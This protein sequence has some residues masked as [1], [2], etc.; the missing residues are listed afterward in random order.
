MIE[1]RGIPI[2]ADEV[3]IL[4]KI[5]QTVLQEQGR[6]ILHKIKKSGN[7]IQVCCPI[8]NQGQERNPSCG[9]ITIKRKDYPAGTF[10]C[11][12]CGAKGSFEYFVSK[13]FQYEDPAFGR[14]WLLDNFVQGDLYE[15]PELPLDFSR[16][17]ILEKNIP[18]F[19]YI[20]EEELA[21]Y[22][23]YH[24]YMFQRKLTHEVIDKYDVGYQKD[25]RLVTINEDGTRK[26]WPPCECL[27][28][29]VKDKY[30][31]C[32]FVSRRAI[33]SKNFY[34]PANMEKPVYGIYELPH[35]CEDV[36]I[37]ESVINALTC[38][39]YGR[40]AVA[41]FGTGNDHQIKQL[42]SLP[43]RHF[44][45]ALD[46]DKAGNKGTWKLK[47]KLKNKLLTKFII[48][49]GKDINDLTYDEFL[50]LPEIYI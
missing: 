49:Q 4:I 25:F 31:N 27:T 35:G 29:P 26:I 15:R 24:P 23:Y 42:N 11:F 34:L 22:R 5:R 8:H 39:G 10:N 47:Y 13:C 41:L 48:P 18:Q 6:E 17:N 32:L 30:G 38:V 2:L 45:L 36:I 7:N 33:Y 14:K 43:I 28:F 46:P 9:I 16:P 20:S 44:I 37:C 1:V 3:D 40:P 21:S 12:A 19:E 50:R